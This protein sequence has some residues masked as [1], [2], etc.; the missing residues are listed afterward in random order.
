MAKH[1]SRRARRAQ[2]VA[3]TRNTIIGLSVFVVG[4]FLTIAILYMIGILPP[5][6]DQP[7]YVVLPDSQTPPSLKI[8]VVE[9]FSY[10]CIHCRNY[11]RQISAW[12]RQ[13]PDDV[14]FERVPVTFN[15]LYRHYAQSY[16]T[17]ESAHALEENHDRIF[18][19][20]HDKGRALNTISLMA[21]LVDG[22][23]T[24]DD[25][26]L[27][28]YSSEEVTERMAKASRTEEI[29]RLNTIPALLIANRYR[30]DVAEV[31]RAA[32]LRI[33]DEIID[34]VRRGV[35]PPPPMQESLR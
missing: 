23:G 20:L 26:F 19:A 7:R 15:S 31:G 2:Q 34:A 29:A 27:A 33:A 13:L 35:P 21:S 14:S 12:V 32:S 8:S 1:I 22:N 16:Y 28:W 6:A 5:S 10:G 30:I 18:V 3:R 4:G 17:L 11:E 24:S 25:T 9:L